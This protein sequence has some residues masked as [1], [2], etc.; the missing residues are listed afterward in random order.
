MLFYCII[1]QKGTLGGL[2]SYT[3][4]VDKKLSEIAFDGGM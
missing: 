3:L 2:T 4:L 1:T